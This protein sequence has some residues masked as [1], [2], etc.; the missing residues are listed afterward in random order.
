MKVREASENVE[1]WNISNFL[2]CYMQGEDICIG[3][4]E[5]GENGVETYH[6]FY[7]SRNIQSS[8]A[9]LIPFNHYLIDV[10]V[11]KTHR[12]SFLAGRRSKNIYTITLKRLDINFSNINFDS[13]VNKAAG[14][15]KKVFFSTPE[16]IH[17]EKEA[18]GFLTL[19]QYREMPPTKRTFLPEKEEFKSFPL[20]KWTHYDVDF[21]H[22]ML[23]EK[24][25]AGEILYLRRK[26]FFPLDI[27]KTIIDIGAGDEPEINGT[28]QENEHY[29][30]L[31]MSD[32]DETKGE[33]T[34]L[35]T[36]SKRQC[37]EK[38]YFL[39]GRTSG[40]FFKAGVAYKWEGA[41]WN[42]LL[43]VDRYT[44]EY[45]KIFEDLRHIIAY[46]Q[47]PEFSQIAIQAF[48]MSYTLLA[49]EAMTDRLKVRG[50]LQLFN[51][52]TKNPHIKGMAYLGDNNTLRISDG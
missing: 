44:K 17:I 25:S 12:V 24:M 5:I 7:K 30:G 27:K 36:H 33:V 38:D 23:F 26:F 2:V 48:T 18:E 21:A 3:A 35:S 45:T 29:L 39:M 16:D 19:L 31:C 1:L 6:T 49:K 28:P 10:E 13:D 52:P 22:I 43:P 46:I 42:E 9:S 47:G 15:T 20:F 8:F 41:K 34:T 11:V 32:V 14:H 51:L 4:K 40:S 50:N 37:Q